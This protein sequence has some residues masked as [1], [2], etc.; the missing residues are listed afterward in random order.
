[1][2]LEIVEGAY[3]SS[4]HRCK[5]SFPLDNYAPPDETD[6]APGIPYSGSGGGRDGRKL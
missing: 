4:R 5:V 2:A 3:L 1:M 6:W